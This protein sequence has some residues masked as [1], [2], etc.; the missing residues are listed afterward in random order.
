M[1]ATNIF[2]HPCFGLPTTPLSSTALNTKTPNPAVG[3]ITN[4]TVNGRYMQL[5]ARFFF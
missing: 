3:Q 1:D 5:G 4:T 2:N